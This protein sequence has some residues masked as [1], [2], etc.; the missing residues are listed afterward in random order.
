[1]YFADRLERYSLFLFFTFAG[2][3]SIPIGFSFVEKGKIAN[4]GGLSVFRRVEII[5]GIFSMEHFYGIRSG[6]FIIFR[7]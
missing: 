5:A 6:G 3:T 2:G 4:Q 1:M 7:G